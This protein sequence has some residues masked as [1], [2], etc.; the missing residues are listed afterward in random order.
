MKKIFLV[1]LVLF[2]KTTFAQENYWQQKLY[3][4]IDVALDE[5]EKMLT[6]KETVIY[7]NNAPVALDF[8][9]FHIWPNAYK[10]NTT[11]L[12]QQINNDESRKK[13][14]KG[15]T[16]GSIEG[17]A[18]SVNGAAAQTEA[19][20]NPA[21]IDIIKLKLPKALLPGDSVSISTPF[22][23]KLPEYFSRSGYADGQFMLCQWYPKPAVFDK[24]GWHEMPYLD[25]GEFYSEYA[26]YK[27]NIQLPSDF[28]V[29][30]T[31][32]LSGAELNKYKTI[33]T[34]NAKDR[35]GKPAMY[36]PGDTITKTLSFAANNVPD[37]AWFADRDLVIQYDTVQ[38][39][40]GKIVDAFSYYHNKKNS[41]WKN[42][43][44]YIKAAVHFY[45]NAVGEYDYPVVQAI[46]G[47][48]NNSSGGMEYPMVTLITSPDAKV[49][50][51]DAVITHE[52]G[53]NWFMSMLGS[54]ER[55]HTWQDEGM[56]SY[57]Q[58]RYE[59]EKYRVNSIFGDAIPEE[60]KKL[61]A[62]D[63]QTTVYN[64]LQNVPMEP[65]IETP[66]ASFTSSNDYGVVSYVKAAIWMYLLEDA[67]GQKKVDA[68]FQYYFS[69]WKHKHPQPGDMKLA[70]EK[71]IGS[72]LDDFFNM[73][74]KKG[75][76]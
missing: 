45:S 10:N 64:A 19:H 8:I 4:T 13:K 2:C 9:W 66:A 35:H 20:A 76:L 39:A 48:K 15:K 58:F 46:E 14:L 62:K 56:N 1:S 53:H 75:K 68:A 25:M 55:M 24:D 47:P 59:A 3:Y 28:V 21:Y 50:T 29:A 67:I 38:L 12:F 52:V 30:A 5:K 71:S 63:F 70:F 7:K 34:A 17:L 26:D 54:N 42:S 32:Q 49:E 72:N 44:D 69:Q 31:G 51:L 40:S 41:L 61:T 57:Y 74:D 37:F 16:S 73:L 36:S 18:F 22:S 27:V 6:G 43:I 11:A 23:V 60:L 33:G 65:A